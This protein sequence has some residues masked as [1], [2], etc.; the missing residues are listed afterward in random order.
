[1]VTIPSAPAVLPITPAVEVAG[2]NH[3]YGSGELRKQALFDIGLK[4]HRGEVVI[5]TGPS[6][7][8]KTTLLTL[9]GSLRTVMEGSLKVLGNELLGADR[10]TIARM[11]MQFGFIFQAHNLFESL[12]AYQNVNMAAELVGLDR[13]EA[14][15]RIRDLL[16]RLGLEQHIQKKP[17]QLSGGQ[18]QRV[19]IARGLVHQPRVVLADE[20]TAAL[21]EKSGRDVVTM[22]QRLAHEDGCTVLMV[23]HDN[24][25]LDVADRMVKIVDG[26]VYS[27]VLVDEAARICEFL[28]AISFFADLTP[29]TL[30]EMAEMMSVREADAGET[31]IRQG[32]AG[33]YFYLIRSGRVAVEVQE[34]GTT[35]RKAELTEGHYFGEAAL[36]H[37]QPRNASVIALEPSVLYALDKDE[38]RRV[39]DQS[40]TFDEEIRQALFN[41]R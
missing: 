26:R 31:I 29:H 32:D 7:H 33:D 41:R 24:R 6:G 39:I 27:N 2:L 38:F 15:Q 16:G 36:I 21:D 25:I 14:D 1:M 28:R 11:R 10:A 34:K 5:I 12:T 40:A 22:F 9:I 18:K 30:S 4:I 17:K 35:S 8:G 23:T 20:P 19:A 3:Y 13:H 37:E